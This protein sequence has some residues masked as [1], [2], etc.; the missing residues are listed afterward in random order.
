MLTLSFLQPDQE[1]TVCDHATCKRHFSYFTRRHHCRKCGNIFCDTHSAFEVPLDQDA[2]YNP[3]GVPSR[4]CAHCYAQFKEWRS[5]A[6]SQPPPTSHDS[7]ENVQQRLD[8]PASP[9][10]ASPVSTSPAVPSGLG[11]PLH[12]PDAAHSV[13][14]DWN[15]STF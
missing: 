7:P 1:S 9:V 6:S 13:P 12:S 4:A 5:R 8:T 11:M 10:S 2:D 3:R 15:W 14:R